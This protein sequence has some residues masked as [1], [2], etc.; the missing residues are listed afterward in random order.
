M[1]AADDDTLYA[2]LGGPEGLRKAVEEF[3]RRVLLDPQLDSYF[4]HLDETALRSLRWHMVA[5][6]SAAAGGPP[7][8]GGRELREA[9]ANLAIADEAFDRVAAHLLETLEHLGVAEED[10]ASVLAAVAPTKPLIVGEVA[11]RAPVTPPRRT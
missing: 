5:F 10:R 11:A 6:L 1:A 2:R 8:Y 4:A 9:H 3:Y 7:R